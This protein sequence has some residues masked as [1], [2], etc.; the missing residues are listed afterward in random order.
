MQTCIHTF[1]QSFGTGI[2]YVLTGFQPGVNKNNKNNGN[3]F[4]R[5]SLGWTNNAPFLTLSV[6]SLL[7]RERLVGGDYVSFTM[8]STCQ[9]RASENEK[10][11]PGYSC[12]HAFIHSCKH[13]VQVSLTFSPGFNPVIIKNNKKT[14]GTVLTVYRYD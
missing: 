14:M 5:L 9:L 13:L 12:N 3:G 4:N 11:N 1:M 7:Q 8:L 10:S 6:V 2:T